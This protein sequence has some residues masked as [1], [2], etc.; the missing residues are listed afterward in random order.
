MTALLRLTV[1]ALVVATVLLIVRGLAIVLSGD[2]LSVGYLAVVLL[3]GSA[4]GLLVPMAY[5][6]R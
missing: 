2:S 5:G 3:D 1:G 6:R 4:L